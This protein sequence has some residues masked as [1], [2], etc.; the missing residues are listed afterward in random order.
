MVCKV[1]ILYGKI[2]VKDSGKRKQQQENEVVLEV[3][4]ILKMQIRKTMPPLRWGRGHKFGSTL[5]SS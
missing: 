4:L 2:N 5:S 1:D 3:S